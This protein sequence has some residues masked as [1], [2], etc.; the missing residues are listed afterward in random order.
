MMDYLSTVSLADIIGFVLIFIVGY[1]Y[2]KKVRE[3]KQLTP[4]YKVGQC[5]IF[6]HNKKKKS[7]VILRSEIVGMCSPDFRIADQNND[8]VITVRTTLKVRYMVD[9]MHAKYDYNIHRSAD[10]IRVTPD[11]RKI[12]L[13]E[14]KVDIVWVDEDNVGCVDYSNEVIS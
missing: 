14:G 9:T 8:E 11:G 3:G 10:F 1:R 7:G 6:E 2:G 13:G 4:K 5:I 12:D